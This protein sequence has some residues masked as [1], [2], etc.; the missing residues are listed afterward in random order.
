MW[1]EQH[2]P[3]GLAMPERRDVAHDLGR[4]MLQEKNCVFWYEIVN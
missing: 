2:V 3:R 1:D 4:I